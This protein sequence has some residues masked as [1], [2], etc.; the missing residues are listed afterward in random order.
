MLKLAKFHYFII[1]ISLLSFTYHK[2]GFIPY[3][4]RCKGDQTLST[5]NQSGIAR[6]SIGIL[7]FSA[8]NNLVN[9]LTSSSRSGLLNLTDD[10]FVVINFSELQSEEEK[11]CTDFNL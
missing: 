8:P 9:T 10:V 2:S 4:N 1:T 5:H 6:I 7:T 11:V 3:D